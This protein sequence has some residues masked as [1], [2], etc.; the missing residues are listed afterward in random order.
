VTDPAYA[1]KTQVR[2]WWRAELLFATNRIILFLGLLRRYVRVH[3]MWA[4]AGLDL[5]Q[6]VL[7]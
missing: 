2:T 3:A 1:A 4:G 5:A 6:A 7:A